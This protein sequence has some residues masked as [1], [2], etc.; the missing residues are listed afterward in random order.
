MKRKKSKPLTFF[1]ILGIILLLILGCLKLSAE[2]EKT[3][4]T[5]TEI[6]EMFKTNNLA[7]KSQL[8]LKLIKRVGAEKAQDEL[9]NSG[10]PFTGQT[11]LLNH[12]VGEY[13]YE[14]YGV[15]GI[16]KCRDYFSASCYHGVI[17]EAIENEGF[18]S[19]PKM[20]E[21]CREQGVAVNSQCSHALGHGLVAYFGYS[22]LTTALQYCD[23]METKVEEFYEYRCHVGV[24]M[25][26]IWG[27]HEVGRSNESWVDPNNFTY[28][29]SDPRINK[30]YQEGCWYNQ[31]FLIEQFTHGNWTRVGIE[32]LNQ[33]D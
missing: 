17:I 31:A 29:C 6:S 14:K 9:K 12:V 32:C 3:K 28:P 10:M 26:N 15:Q 4:S 33:S 24:F 23:F 8:Y 16:I 1:I 18:D 25:E 2:S 5:S 13:I 30:K 27:L 11:H 7:A 22:N 20:L 19:I 21:T